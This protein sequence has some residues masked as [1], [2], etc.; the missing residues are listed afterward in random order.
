MGSAAGLHGPQAGQCLPVSPARAHAACLWEGPADGRVAEGAGH[1]SVAAAE[2][3]CTTAWTAKLAAALRLH[4]PTKYVEGR[5]SPRGSAVPA[6][7]AELMSAT[8]AD[9]E[10]ATQGFGAQVPAC[11]ASVHSVLRQHASRFCAE[12]S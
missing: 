4:A 9:A 10:A 5:L 12:A 6:Q 3:G 7:R 2:A 1:D 11:L 8:V